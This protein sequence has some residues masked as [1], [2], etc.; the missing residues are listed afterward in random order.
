MNKYFLLVVLALVIPGSIM[1]QSLYFDIGLGVGNAIT[2]IDGEDVADSLGSSIDDIGVD[3]SVKLGVGPVFNVPL[4][5][6]GDIGGIGHRLYDDDHYL[7]FNSYLI[8]PGVVFYPIP[9][10][11]IGASFGYSFV[12]NDT[13]L[14]VE[15]YD[16]E[17]GYAGNVSI[18]FDFGAEKHGCL[19]GVKYAFA[20]NTLEV[21]EVEQKSTALTFMIKYAY[22]Q[23]L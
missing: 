3:F 18:A 15:M 17:S 22:R 6:V 16:S 23:K 20:E 1:A 19:L 4:Y 13:D 5:I 7:Q 10:I 2:E 8:G 9:L 21:S 12:A 11:Q 14:P